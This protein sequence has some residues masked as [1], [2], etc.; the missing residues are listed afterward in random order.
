MHGF[1]NCCIRTILGVTKSEQWKKRIRSDQLAVALGMEE[2]MADIL[3]RHR[4][5][6]LEH[7]ARMESNRLP[8]QLPFGELVKKRPCRGTKR[9]WGDVAAADIKTGEW[10]HL[11]RRGAF[12]EQCVRKAWLH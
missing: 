3:M 10:Y 2:K 7:L 11:A 1:H 4:L 8:K 9:R 5:R 12:G 6:W